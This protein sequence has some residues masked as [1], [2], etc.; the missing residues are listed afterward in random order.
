MFLTLFLQTQLIATSIL[1]RLDYFGGYVDLYNGGFATV[2]DE[3]GVS[4]IDL[5]SY[6][7]EEDTVLWAKDGLHLSECTGLPLY[8]HLLNDEVH[9]VLFESKLEKIHKFK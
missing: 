8:M 2:C 5:T 1:P 4:W 3:E 6:F 7:P 9:R